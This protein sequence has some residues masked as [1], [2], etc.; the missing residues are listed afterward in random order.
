MTEKGR[1]ECNR[2]L[3]SRCDALSPSLLPARP[4]FVLSLA[5]YPPLPDMWYCSSLH[6]LSSSHTL[7]SIFPCITRNSLTIHYLN[8]DSPLETSQPS[9]TP[10]SRRQS[11]SPTIFHPRSRTTTH[12]TSRGRSYRSEFCVSWWWSSIR[13]ISSKNF[14]WLGL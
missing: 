10:S 4:E 7:C 5:K 3:P 14:V 13:N 11:S 1:K 6:F 8:T 9:H 12:K 2:E